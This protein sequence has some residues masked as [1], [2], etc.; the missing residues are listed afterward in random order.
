MAAMAVPAVVALATIT[1]V[2]LVLA[3]ATAATAAA[4][5]EPQAAPDKAP[6]QENL[7]HPAVRCIPAAVAAVRI[8]HLP[9]Q[10]VLAAAVQAP[11]YGAAQA[12]PV[13]PTPAAAAVAAAVTHT[14]Q[15]LLAA[16]GLWLFATT[17]DSEAI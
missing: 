4:I 3:A 7:A 13:Q 5:V 15:A 12:L 1:M 8:P 6:R 16:A 11:T 9:E 2:M 10:A 17:E 14:A